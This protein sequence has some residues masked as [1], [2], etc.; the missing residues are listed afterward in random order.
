MIFYC[1]NIILT[2]THLFL[3]SYHIGQLPIKHLDNCLSSNVAYSLIAIFRTLDEHIKFLLYITY[4]HT[5]YSHLLEVFQ[6]RY[7][8]TE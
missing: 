4:T 3:M 6:L 8:V 1:K 7:S 5:H 2:K